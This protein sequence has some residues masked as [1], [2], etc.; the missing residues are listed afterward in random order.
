MALAEADNDAI[1]PTAAVFVPFFVQHELLGPAL[2]GS[3]EWHSVRR[4]GPQEQ[5]HDDSSGEDGR[6][7]LIGMRMVLLSVMKRS[8]VTSAE[9]PLTSMLHPR[10]AVPRGDAT[11]V[12]IPSEGPFVRVLMQSPAL[13]LEG[14]PLKP[15]MQTLSAASRKSLRSVGW[16]S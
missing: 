15:S 11:R 7:S 16:P 2:R 4:I 14:F 5:C 8:A 3:G 13:A 10:A 1:C 12:P 9:K 6:A